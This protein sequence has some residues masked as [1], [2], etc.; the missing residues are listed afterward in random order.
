MFQAC[1]TYASSLLHKKALSCYSFRVLMKALFILATPGCTKEE[2]F[3]CFCQLALQYTCNLKMRSHSH[4]APSHIYIGHNICYKYNLEL[5][6][7][8]LR[9][10]LMMLINYE[11]ITQ[12][13]KYHCSA[14]SKS[15]SKE[16]KSVF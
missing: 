12:A 7:L 14:W 3:P 2:D 10:I 16:K 5:P 13:R 1:I 11:L 6:M 9:V 4:F 15:K 8:K